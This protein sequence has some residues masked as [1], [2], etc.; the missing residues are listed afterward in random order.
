VSWL[1]VESPSALL[2]GLAAL[3]SAVGGI[4]STVIAARKVHRDERGICEEKLRAIRL[5]AG[6]LA[7]EIYRLKTRREVP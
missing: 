6:Q 1:A 2:L 7:E 3:V 4:V 5:E